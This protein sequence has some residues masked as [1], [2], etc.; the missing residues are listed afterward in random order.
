MKKT[1]S[2]AVFWGE[3]ENRANDVPFL[4]LSSEQ[5][6]FQQT[7]ALKRTNKVWKFTAKNARAK[8][9]SVQLKRVI[10]TTLTHSRLHEQYNSMKEDERN[11]IKQRQRRSCKS[12]S[13][14][15]C[16]SMVEWLL[17]LCGVCHRECTLKRF[18]RNLG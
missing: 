11:N 12:S 13:I 16:L 7:N 15:M 10:H 1:S 18:R 14:V 8:C 6:K 5:K 3:S 17:F 2:V 9:F 4:D